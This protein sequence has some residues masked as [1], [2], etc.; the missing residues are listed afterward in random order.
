VFIAGPF[1][2]R[3]VAI[4]TGMDTAHTTIRIATRTGRT[5]R[6]TTMDTDMGRIGQ[7]LD[8]DTGRT[9]RATDTPISRTIAMAITGNPITGMATGNGGSSSDLISTIAE[10]HPA[11]DHWFR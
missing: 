3:I 4:T 8:T 1:G 10:L 7:R 9:G 11:G 6:I 2:A 5:S